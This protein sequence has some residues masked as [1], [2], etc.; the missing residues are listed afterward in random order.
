MTKTFTYNIFYLRK[1]KEDDAQAFLE[2]SR[3]WEV[4]KYYGEQGNCKNMEQAENQVR[5]ALGEFEK[6]GG[7][8]IIADQ[9]SGS[10]IGDVGFHGFE[11]IHRRDEIGYRL[12]KAYWGR[13]IMSAF[14]SQLLSWGFLELNYNR[15]EALVDPR[16]PASARTLEKNGFRKE[17]LLRDYEFEYGHFIDL[18]MYSLLKRDLM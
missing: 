11:N 5:W 8:W 4:M 2:I 15:V 18:E 10:Y 12:N 16:N 14:I 13:G 6:N 3:D 9:A 17:G 1:P 7:R